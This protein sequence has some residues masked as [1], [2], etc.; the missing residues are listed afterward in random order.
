[1]GA[2]GWWRIVVSPAVFEE[3]N[4]PEPKDVS[5]TH[6]NLQLAVKS[7][8]LERIHSNLTSGGALVAS[9]QYVKSDGTN[10]GM[11]TKS[12]PNS[13][14]GDI[15]ERVFPVAPA[16]HAATPQLQV[17]QPRKTTGSGG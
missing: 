17:T 7:K 4:M 15:W 5:K 1:V 13:S 6:Q 14:L 11:Y 2:F 12:D 10:Y 3:K 9:T 16:T 8:I